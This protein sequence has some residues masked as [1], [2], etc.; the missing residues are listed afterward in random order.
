[1]REAGAGVV[2]DGHETIVPPSRSHR[3]AA[4]VQ[5][6]AGGRLAST[7]LAHLPLGVAVIDADQRLLFWNEQAA[8]VFGVPPSLATDLPRLADILPG[9]VDL[10]PRQRDGIIAFGATHIAAGDRA[11]PESCLRLSLGRNRR[12]AIQIRGIGA[13]RWMLV[14]DDGKLAAVN[15][16]SE[17]T[18]GSGVAWLDALT[19][20]SNRRHFNQVLADLVD[21]A[22]PGSKH[23]VLMIDLDR[24]KPI[25]DTL[26]H[27]VGD[28]LLCL[29]AQ[30][31]R[32]ETREDDLLARLGGDEFVVLIANSERAEPLAARLIDALARPFLV[33]GHV[34]NIGASIG[35]ARFPAGE[36]S[37][38]DLMRHAGLALY[39]AKSAGRRTWRMFEPDMATDAQVRRALET[40]LRK[41]LTLGEFSLAYQ[42]QFN[43]E[44][45]A[46]T[47]FEA[48]LRWN[49]PIR[50]AVPPL[51][52]IPIAEDI[53][54]IVALGEWVLKTACKEAARWP[55]SLTVAVNVSPRQLDDSARLLK[56]VQ[57]ALQASGLAPER[58]ELEITESSLLATDQRVLETLHQLSASGIRIA[59]DD[60]GTGYSS[61]S[62][63]RSFPFN[64][65]KID[66]SFV[67]GLGVD[68]DAPAMIRAIAALGAGLG[69]TTIAEGVETAEQA[70]LVEADGC[71]NIQ[72]YLI[73]RPI[74]AAEIDALLRRHVLAPD[75]SSTG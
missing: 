50:G 47:G 36:A 22:P 16:R 70:A 24:F 56:A 23:A 67:A 2:L 19:G 6:R 43:V 18:Q 28:A 48:L 58:L 31:L 37:S 62:Q 41:A 35:I 5:A 25:N 72:G 64:K 49:H 69:M 65:I 63:L 12:I 54:C 45:K 26:G 52:F 55:V 21:N 68:D 61:L 51:E 32:R 71:V 40:D 30:R 59:M 60:F 17:T 13:D 11:E 3:G 46:L 7:V 9:M 14:I 1:V 42:A 39:D 27:S 38:D 75:N 20:L 73:S 10:T 29:V 33:E 15:G 66:Q 8:A 44:R 53:G 74:A 57:S 4:A 34:A